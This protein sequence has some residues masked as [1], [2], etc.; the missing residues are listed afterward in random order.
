MSE[1]TVREVPDPSEIFNNFEIITF[2][3]VLREIFLHK[4]KI[5]SELGIL[6]KT[7]LGKQQ[8]TVKFW[9]SQKIHFRRRQ[10]VSLPVIPQKRLMH[11]IN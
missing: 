6:L 3:Q 7:F 10:C 8:N 2:T 9:K 1:T 11:K 4:L 5:N